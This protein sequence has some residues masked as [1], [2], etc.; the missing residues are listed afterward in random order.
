MRNTLPVIPS[1]L[2]ILLL[3]VTSCGDDYPDLDF[4]Q[5]MRDFVTAISGYAKDLHPGFL[6]IPQNGQELNTLNGD[7]KGSP[8][9]E[10]LSV[11][12]C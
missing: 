5:E 10:Y 12:D 8:N 2:I 4:K 11:I 3:S 7:N 1:G 9:L 6:I